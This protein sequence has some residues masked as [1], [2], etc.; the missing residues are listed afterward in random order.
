MIDEGC[1]RSFEDQPLKQVIQVAE[2]VRSG[3]RLALNF[4][5]R[6]VARNRILDCL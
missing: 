1:K 2:V 5:L 3:V 6:H 4:R